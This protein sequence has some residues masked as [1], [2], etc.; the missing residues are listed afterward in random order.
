MTRGCPI[1]EDSISGTPRN[2]E[3]GV[4]YLSVGS[5]GAECTGTVSRIK[6]CYHNSPSLST[7]MAEARM[8]IYR[9]QGFLTVNRVSDEFT[10][11]NRVPFNG[12]SGLVCEYLE[13]Q[14]PVFV[15]ES[16]LFGVCVFSARSAETLPVVSGA[17]EGSYLRVS[18]C[19]AQSIDSTSLFSFSFMD[20]LTLHLSADIAAGKCVAISRL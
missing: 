20:K 16:D 8:A 1:G 18:S 17:S 14:A 19:D 12:T 5:E 6:Y 10:I 4:F 2:R 9:R 11:T 7:N 3:T 13:L 15:E